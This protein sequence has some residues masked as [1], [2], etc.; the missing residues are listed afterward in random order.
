MVLGV[1]LGHAVPQS[2]AAIVPKVGRRNS[3]TI[4][5]PGNG[6]PVPEGVRAD[7]GKGAPVCNHEP[8]KDHGSQ[9]N[10]GLHTAM[11]P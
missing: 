7:A 11:L 2:K 8:D 9:K 3:K 1:L 6:E 5:L 4:L 10:D